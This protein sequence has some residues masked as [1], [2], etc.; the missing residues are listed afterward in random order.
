MEFVATERLR[1][2]PYVEADAPRVLEILSHPDVYPWLGD[3]PQHP[4]ADL[5]AARAW[6]ERTNAREQPGAFHVYRAIELRQSGV[7][8][9][10]VLVAPMIR[11]DGTDLGEHELGWHLHPD[12]WGNGYATEAARI[13]LDG[14]FAAGLPDIWVG[15][16][17][18]NAASRAVAER[19]GLPFLGIQA[20]P[21]YEGDSP[22][23]H[24]TA[25]EWAH[26]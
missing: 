14:V 22:L 16:M 15:M 12:S 24:V 25:K 2:R 6:I 19:L 3:P 11:K 23:F 17:V 18:E 9:G 26:R 7:V 20:D 1:L 13:M 8:A 21:W 4:M 10:T 5:A